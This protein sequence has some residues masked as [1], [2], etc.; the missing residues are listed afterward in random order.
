M[1]NRPFSVSRPIPSHWIDWVG[2]VVDFGLMENPKLLRVDMTNVVSIVDDSSE[3][4]TI[5]RS[6]K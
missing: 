1:K 4:E 5:R 6:S 2:D 3:S